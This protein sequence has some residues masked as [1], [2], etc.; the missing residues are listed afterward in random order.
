MPNLDLA[1]LLRRN[2]QVD[3]DKVRAALELH[4]KFVDLGGRRST[5]TLGGGAL[6]VPP[7]TGVEATPSP[8]R[9]GSIYSNHR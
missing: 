7:N 8:V 6:P 5:Y 1:E 9:V 4:Q 3:S 2:Q